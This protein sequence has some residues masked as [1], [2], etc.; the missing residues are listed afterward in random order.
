LKEWIYSNGT[1]QAVTSTGTYA[2]GQDC[3]LQLTFANGGSAA[4]GN[5]GA[6][7]FQAPSMFTVALNRADGVVGTK[8]LGSPSNFGASGSLI[9]T[10]ANVSTVIGTFLPQ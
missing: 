8:T 2:V 10:P 1:V 9:V 4:G 7:S 6:V 3:R 5:T